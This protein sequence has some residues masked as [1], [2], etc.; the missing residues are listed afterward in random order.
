MLNRT[1]LS[2]NSR[3]FHC[4]WWHEQCRF[5]RS[6]SIMFVGDCTWSIYK[7]IV[8]VLI[9]KDYVSQFIVVRYK[10]LNV[11]STKSMLTMN[12][13][14]LVIYLEFQGFIFVRG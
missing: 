11:Y 8:I 3:D 14:I 13:F 9:L 2:F 6:L 1:K 7:Q 12:I 5:F 4:L 10:L